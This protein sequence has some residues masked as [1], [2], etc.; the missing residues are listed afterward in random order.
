M[1]FNIFHIFYQ[2]AETK[3][4]END[5]ESAAVLDLTDP[6]QMAALLEGYINEDPLTSTAETMDMISALSVDTS[7][8]DARHSSTEPNTVDKLK[9]KSPNKIQRD[10][11]KPSPTTASPK[12]GVKTI[13][14]TLA[15]RSTANTVASS[16]MQQSTS[17]TRSNELNISAQTLSEGTN[18]V[19]LNGTLKHS[20]VTVVSAIVTSATGSLSY[21]S[22]NSKHAD[23]GTGP[24]SAT[25]TKLL[26]QIDKPHKCHVCGE[27]FKYE[28]TLNA[29]M[30]KHKEALPAWESRGV[31]VPYGAGVKSVVLPKAMPIKPYSCPVCKETFRYVN[32]NYKDV[33]ITVQS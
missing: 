16:T 5:V 22:T 10:S 21:T 24:M 29:H 31:L 25:E 11:D 8:T 20:N 13:T 28:F 23:C 4:G 15:A 32:S 6:Q 1:H 9:N 30:P 19:I 14:Y 17:V 3:A 12:Q 2:G 26:E 18:Q 7:G 27:C 33:A